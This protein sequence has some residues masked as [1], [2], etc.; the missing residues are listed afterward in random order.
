MPLLSS[1]S[2]QLDVLEVPRVLVVLERSDITRGTAG[3]SIARVEVRHELGR[4]SS[5]VVETTDMT[6]ESL[7]WL[8]GSVAQ[9]GHTV[10]ISMGWGEKTASVFKGEVVGLEL[11]ASNTEPP[12]VSIR[13]FD[14]L[15]RL[16]R[17]RTTRAFVKAKDSDIAGEIARFNGL[18][19]VVP[20]PT[21]IVHPYVMQSDQTDLA[22]LLARARP[23]GYTVR[24]EGT[25]LLFAPRGLADSPLV[26]AELGK[27]LL[28]L[29]IRASALGLPDAVEAR[30]WDPAAQKEIVANV[31]ADDLS[32]MMGG[33]LSGL[34]IAA[35]RFASKSSVTSVPGV[36]IL[37]AAAAEAAAKAELENLALEH[38]VC[39]GRLTG[40]PALRPGSVVAI[41]GF[42]RRFSG[43]YWLTRVVHVHAD[44]GY[45]TEFEGRRTAT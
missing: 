22:F 19:A 45:V 1:T 34:D 38:V 14:R 20:K 13:G 32:A 26:T 33:D 18:G 4:P 7:D 10:E 29:F 3:V 42:G 43:N 35:S 12:R 21:T 5:F 6:P 23:L 16:M 40:S 31:P 36:A 39:E 25:D 17:A 44:D 24:V 8:D 2:P 15:H 41:K 30:G 28:S 37:D 11:E 9:E 27:N